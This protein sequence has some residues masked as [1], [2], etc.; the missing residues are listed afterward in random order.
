MDFTDGDMLQIAGTLDGVSLESAADVTDYAYDLA[1][2]GTLIDFGDGGSIL[3]KGVSYDD[4]A[5]D[6]EKFFTIV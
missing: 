1:D 3:L 4:I 2:G 6:P 5:A